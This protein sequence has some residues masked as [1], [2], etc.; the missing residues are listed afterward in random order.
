M[1]EKEPSD[2]QKQF[3]AKMNSQLIGAILMFVASLAM[4]ILFEMHLEGKI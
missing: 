4:F 1:I 2:F 3:N